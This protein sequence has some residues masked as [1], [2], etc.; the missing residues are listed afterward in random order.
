MELLWVTAIS[1]SIVV[2][3]VLISPFFFGAGG[4][5]ASGI[6]V[7]A[8]KELKALKNQLL[9]LYLEE[10]KALT[11]G[12]ISAAVWQKR[13]VFLSQRYLDVTRR[14]DFIL[15]TEQENDGKSL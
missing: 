14:L 1:I 4:P 13:Q 6:S 3:L 8:P 5:L 2:F 9:Q 12:L 11:H 15:A 7:S 10:E